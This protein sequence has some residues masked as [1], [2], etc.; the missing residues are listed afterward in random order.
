MIYNKSVREVKYFYSSLRNELERV[1][2]ESIPFLAHDYSPRIPINSDIY[3]HI[4]EFKEGAWYRDQKILYKARINRFSESHIGWGNVENIDIVPK[5]DRYKITR[6]RLNLEKQAL[7]YCSTNYHVATYESIWKG[8]SSE[9]ISQNFVTVGSWKINSP[10]HLARLYYPE[11]G[12]KQFGNQD[13]YREMLRHRKNER[14]Q[15]FEFLEEVGYNGR[16]LDVSMAIMDIMSEE[17]GKLNIRGDFDY[18]ISN[19]Y[20]QMVLEKSRHPK[21]GDYDGILFPSIP[22]SYQGSNIALTESG[23]A[24]LEFQSAMIVW[25]VYSQKSKQFEFIP[26]KQDVIAD[27]K[28]NFD[29][30]VFKDN[31]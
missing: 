2:Y 26:L 6:G 20:S 12:L 25:V 21:F 8:F 27:P 5:L 15:C 22:Y 4:A 9:N 10:L 17:V 14:D 30:G 16:D 19:Y 31:R 13:I 23:R 1:P 11:Q 7:F 24:K 29:W 28:G 3:E 18:K